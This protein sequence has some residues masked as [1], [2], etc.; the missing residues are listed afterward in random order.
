MH[1]WL[2]LRKRVN[3]CRQGQ[4]RQ[5]RCSGHGHLLAR[6]ARFIAKAIDHLKQ[7]AHDNTR[8]VGQTFAMGGE[9]HPTGSAFQQFD[10]EDGFQPL[11]SAGHRWL[12]DM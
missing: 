9:F 4:R 6:Q 7:A 12:G 10:A 11:H 3:Y 5:H 8:F 1:G 2:A